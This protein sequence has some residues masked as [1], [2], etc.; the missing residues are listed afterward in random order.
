[1][2]GSYPPTQLQEGGDTTLSSP[3]CTPALQSMPSSSVMIKAPLSHCPS[4]PPQLMLSGSPHFSNSDPQL[5]GSHPLPYCC[6][7][8][9]RVPSSFF[10][11]GAAARQTLGLLTP[12]HLPSF[13]HITPFPAP[14]VFTGKP[15]VLSHCCP[16]T[17]LTPCPCLCARPLGQCHPV[18]V[19]SSASLL[20]SIPGHSS[21]WGTPIWGAAVA[22]P[23]WEWLPG[24]L[25]PHT[26]PAVHLLPAPLRLCSPSPVP[27]TE[28]VTLGNRLPPSPAPILQ[29]TGHTASPS[30][31]CFGADI[32]GTRTPG[33]GWR[34]RGGPL[35]PKKPMGNGDPALH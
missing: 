5:R 11:L 22:P 34:S 35:A 19:A 18:S 9:A 14:R 7:P 23:F 31:S 15:P 29:D 25:W 2:G 10:L 33:T 21:P 26:L 12:I 32:P 13:P 28:G 20:L 8:S 30:T 17:P 27:G 1:M 16:G 4:I 24:G 3:P 6:P